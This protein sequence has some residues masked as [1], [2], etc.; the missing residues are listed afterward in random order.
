MTKQDK[1]DAILSQ[2]DELY[3]EL[4]E[5]KVSRSTLDA[6]NKVCEEVELD[7]REATIE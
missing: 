2:L 5:M 3:R 1:L 4:K 6:L 7:L